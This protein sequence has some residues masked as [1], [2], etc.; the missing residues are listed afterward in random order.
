MREP[1]HVPK[2]RQHLPTVPQL[3]RLEVIG[4]MQRRGIGTAPDPPG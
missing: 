4:S 1:A 3:H 2:V